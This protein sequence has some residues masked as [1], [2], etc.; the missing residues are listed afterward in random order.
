VWSDLKDRSLLPG[1][2]WWG[3]YGILYDIIYIPLY[4][5]GIVMAVYVLVSK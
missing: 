1:S 3:I 4:K 5:L 2:I